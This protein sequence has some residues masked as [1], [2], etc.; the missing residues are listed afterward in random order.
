MNDKIANLIT[1]IKNASSQGHELITV[2]QSKLVASVA[3]VLLKEG[4]IAGIGKRDNGGDSKKAKKEGALKVIEIKLSYNT[5]E[6]PKVSGVERLSKSSKRVYLGYKNLRPI[7]NGYGIMLLTTPVG[8]MT[9]KEAKKTK[10]G[11][12]P[13]FLMW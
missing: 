4:W 5:D 1:K 7:R 6:T 10:V 12:E 3:E 11:G 9:E 13:L 8:I 2:P